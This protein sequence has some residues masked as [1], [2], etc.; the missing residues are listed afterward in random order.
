MYFLISVVITYTLGSLP[1][2]VWIGK[3]LRNIDI[4]DYGSKNSGATNAYR[5]LGVKYGLLVLLADAI[6]G[7]LPLLIAEK[8]FSI[9]GNYL[10][11]LGL[12]AI[13]GH[14][15]SIFLKFKGGKGV[16][17]S[18]GVFLFLF[19]NGII[20]VLSLFIGILYFTRYVSLASII[21]AGCLPL[22]SLFLPMKANISRP[23]LFIVTAI[24][25]IFVIYKH[26]ENIG[27]LR[28]G[29]ESKFKAKN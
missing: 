17:T 13:I 26:K 8:I 6:K 29:T 16:A 22:L 20:I 1:S 14:S 3:T 7:Y 11:I 27:R 18:L 19:P 4:R 23:L 28:K 10:I 24:V 2:G 21:G 25:A 15:L 9:Q 12:I 5:V